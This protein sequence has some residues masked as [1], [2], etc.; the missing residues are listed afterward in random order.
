MNQK[1]EELKTLLRELFQLDQPD[2]DFGLYR[3]LRARSAEITTF[4]EKD[5][6][7][8]VKEVLE[9]YAEVD[10]KALRSKLEKVEGDLRGL[11][12]DPSTNEIVI[13]LK[14]QLETEGMDL[15][16]VESEIYDHLIVFFR[17]YYAEGDFLTRRAYDKE[18]Y[19][20]P[21][22]GSEV[23][24]HWANKDQYY[25]KTTE[26]FSDFAFRLRPFDDANPM[27]VKFRLAEATEGAHNNA[28]E[29]AAKT[30]RFQL[31]E[32]PFAEIEDGELIINFVYAPYAGPQ[33]KVNEEMEATAIA[34]AEADPRF[35]QWKKELSA[36]FSYADGSK[37][38]NSKFR[39]QLDRYTARNT[40]DYFIHKDLEGFLQRELNFYIKNEVMQLD[41][42]E[43]ET[44]PRVEQYLSKIK[45]IRKIARKLIDFLAQLENFQKKLW[46][47]K[48][49]VVETHYCIAVGAIPEALYAE[50][51]SN[52]AQ[53]EEWVNLLAIDEIKGDIAKAGY[54][55]PL[56][57]AFLKENATLVLDTRN[58]DAN[59]VAQLLEEMGNLDEKTDGVLFDSENFQALSV[60][61]ARYRD[62]V[63][64]IY[65]DPP[66]NTG[67]Q[68]SFAYKDSYQ[69]SSWASMMHDR[70]TL[71]LATAAQNAGIL[72][73]TDDGEYSSLRFVL[74][75]VWGSKNFVADVIWKCRASVSN[76]ALISTSTNHTTFF[77]RNRVLL[78]AQ[79]SR[80][81]LPQP[82]KGFE[83]PNNDPSGPWKLDPMDAPNVRANLS[84]PIV[85]P[86]TKQEFFPP[87]GRHWRFEKSQTDE[88]LAN[89]RIQFGLTGNSR[90]QFKRY[91]S[92]AKEKGKTPTTL[93]DDVSTT[94][95]ATSELLEIFGA[96]GNRQLIDQLKPK[97]CALVERCVVL[98]TDWSDPVLDFFA[99]S[100]T[101]AH[102]VINVNRRDGGQRKFI[103]VEMAD[104]FDTV[105]LPRL[106]KVSFTPE[107]KDGKPKRLAT[108]EEATRSPRIVKV[109]RLE[110]YEDTLNNL[111]LTRTADQQS[112]LDDVVAAGP[113]S[114]REQYLLRYMLGAESQNSASL[115]N[116]QSFTDPAAYQLRVKQAGSDEPQLATVDIVETFN[117]LIGLKVSKLAAGRSYAASFNGGGIEATTLA[118]WNEDQSGPFWFR[119]VTG[120]TPDD[121]SVLVIW[122]TL[123]NTNDDSVED[124]LTLANL[125]LE[126]WF[127]TTFTAEQRQAFGAVFVNGPCTLDALRGDGDPWTVCE[128]VQRFHALMFSDD[129]V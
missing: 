81:R 88:Y 58:F 121:K 94:S 9:G 22:D 63:K 10:K 11:K 33:S 101:T 90:P 23:A 78:E 1:F 86:V 27:R 65:I 76:D 4:L 62:Q 119:Y 13:A 80:F 12:A 61:Q 64:C 17:R 25:I 30:R 79:K 5:L 15:G 20:I 8:Q 107:W 56:T 71:A 87:K 50:I 47:K 28:K 60:M 118:N 7:T 2:L 68:N 84:Y 95:D 72:V 77:A 114:F 122:R 42:V 34:L 52:D 96:A 70:L 24:L 126:A 115:L 37:S 14:K 31:A 83:N 117:W 112:L 49:F 97:P 100:G 3:V 39:V 92:E 38:K 89:G 44:A 53:R 104:Y 59:F 123:P 21:Y 125:V 113:D 128:T 98:L 6:L 93:W 54:S 32:A 116:A 66:Y 40:F 51:A 127:A 102:A 36:K 111:D 75:Q 46:R 106:K 48:K 67:T 85:N 109:V 19:A 57:P 35:E 99:G 16:Q 110:S 105:L 124:A 26:R 74:D 91:L 103:L 69:H 43:S 18:T 29:D 55:S 45:V 41:N 73:S 108:V 82:E 129:G 120:T